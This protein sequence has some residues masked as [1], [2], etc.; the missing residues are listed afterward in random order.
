VKPVLA[1]TLFRKGKWNNALSTISFSEKK[2]KK[3]KGQ[4]GEKRIYLRAGDNSLVVECLSSMSNVLG[5]LKKI[6]FS[7]KNKRIQYDS[8]G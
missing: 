8:Q 2:K 3:K 5:V 4:R 6:I 7:G 1:L